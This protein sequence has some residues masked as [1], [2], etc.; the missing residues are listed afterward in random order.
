MNFETEQTIRNTLAD[1][2]AGRVHFGEV[3]ARL[4]S[5]GVESYCVDYRN[6]RFTYYLSDDQSLT[7]VTQASEVLIGN[8]FIA[9]E[10]QAAIRQ[11]QQGIVKFPEFKKL[12]KQAGCIGY[13]V[14]IAG[15]HV[16]YLGR[17]GEQHIE[18]FPNY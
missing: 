12:S 8:A 7:L 17:K 4:D 16:T 3:V 9:T 6:N 18:K 15:K 14:W 10:I 1:S 13:T 2:E 5:V 11:A